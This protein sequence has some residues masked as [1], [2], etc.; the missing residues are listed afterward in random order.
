MVPA[1]AEPENTADTGPAAAEPAAAGGAGGTPASEEGTPSEEEA[2]RRKKREEA[3]AKR[4]EQR[5][6]TKQQMAK[7]RERFKQGLPTSPVANDSARQNQ[8][9]NFDAEVDLE[10]KSPPPSESPKN[11]V[12]SKDA[13]MNVTDYE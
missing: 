6:L 9:A 4:E 10:P 8:I 2:A 3:K 13:G 12:T 5:K 1:P 11:G 7:D